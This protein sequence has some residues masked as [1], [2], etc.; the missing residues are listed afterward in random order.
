MWKALQR[1]ERDE[2]WLEV[3]SGSGMIIWPSCYANSSGSRPTTHNKMDKKL[4]GE[5]AA[6]PLGNSF[7]HSLSWSITEKWHYCG[8]LW[9]HKPKRKSSNK[10]TGRSASETGSFQ[11]R[12]RIQYRDGEK[13]G[14]THMRLDIQQAHFLLWEDWT[15]RVQ[16]CAVEIPFVLAML[17]EPETW[18]EEWWEKARTHIFGWTHGQSFK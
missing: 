8:G 2:I 10:V 6:E 14:V 9:W 13:E 1:Y 7:H 16:T 18:K 12:L 17:N 4:N 5:G 11:N 15:Y 3:V